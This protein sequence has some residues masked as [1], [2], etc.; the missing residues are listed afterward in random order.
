MFPKKPIIVYTPNREYQDVIVYAP[1]LTLAGAYRDADILLADAYSDIPK[2]YKG[3][4]FTTN[5]AV[6]A[7]NS[8]AVGAFYWEHGR[9]RIYFLQR[10]L[11]ANDISLSR[12]M[13]R[14][15]VKEIP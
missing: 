7:K 6:F 11:E 14:Y 3:V 10:R 4:V 2:G 9:P 8:Q 12:G 13:Q 1:S 5:A 15:I